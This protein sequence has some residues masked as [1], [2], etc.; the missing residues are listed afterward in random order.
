MLVL[1]N[2][3]KEQLH[4][5]VDN[6]TEYKIVYQRKWKSTSVI[7]SCHPAVYVACLLVGLGVNSLPEFMQV[8]VVAFPF[9]APLTAKNKNSTWSQ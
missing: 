3:D 6:T 2:C 9:P 5:R 7:M 1:K 8:A 4:Y